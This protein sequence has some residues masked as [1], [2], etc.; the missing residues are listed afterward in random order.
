[1]GKNCEHYHGWRVILFGLV[2]SVLELAAS[3]CD[4]DSGRNQ[5]HEI[6]AA[7]D[8]DQACQIDGKSAKRFRCLSAVAARMPHHSK[9][10]QVQAKTPQSR[11]QPAV[12]CNGHRIPDPIALDMSLPALASG[13]FVLL[14]IQQKQP[15]GMQRRPS[16]GPYAPTTIT[17]DL[18]L[19][20]TA[21]QTLAP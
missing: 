9:M 6:A 12:Q 11:V 10:L 3:G 2:P 18:I 21:A 20:W 19:S 17:D 8:G 4:K 14:K 13:V 15:G 7:A 5:R 1:M 16:T